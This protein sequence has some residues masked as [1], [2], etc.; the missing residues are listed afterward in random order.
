MVIDGRPRPRGSATLTNRPISIRSVRSGKPT[1]RI[2]GTLVDLRQIDCFLTV[3][4]ELHFGKAAERLFLA[5]SSVSEAIRSLE[6]EVGGR[7]FIRTSRRVQLTDLGA[8]LRLGVEPAALVLRA[9]L[10]DC[11][12]TALGK[13]NRLRIGFLGGGLYELTLP[14]VRQLKSQFNLDVDWVELTLL[15]QFEAVA[16]GKVDAAFCRLPLSHDG[17]VQ[18][19]ILFEDKRKLV[20]PVDHR[21]A[22][23]TLVDP[24]ELALETLPTLPDDHQLGA[25]AAIHF[26]D[27]TPSGLPIA[28]GPVVTTV[29]ECLAVVESGKA[30]V[31]FGSRTERYYSSPGIRYIEIDLPPVNTALVRRRADRRRVMA[32]LEKCSRHVAERLLDLRRPGARMAI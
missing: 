29:R 14:F 27:H 31:L 30:V 6:H 16:A 18:S 28:R 25:W 21:L 17:L 7:L 23:S 8:K 3:A 2:R 22:E 9:T 11:R 13:S 32:D 15:D 24:E 19:A 20:V 1:D 4:T 5:Q 10:E 26:P 12:K